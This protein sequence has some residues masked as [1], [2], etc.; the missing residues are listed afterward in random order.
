[1]RIISRTIGAKI[2]TANSDEVLCALPIPK[3]GKVLSVQGELHVIGQESLDIDNFMGYGFMGELVPIVDPTTAITAQALWDNVVVKAGDPTVSAGTN[4][5]DFDWDTLDTGPAIEPGELDIDKLLNLVQ[6]QKEI[7]A[8]RMEWLSWAKNKQGGWI[9]G[10]PDVF[11]PTD[12]KTFRSRKT[13]LADVPSM[14]MLAFSNPL[15][16]DVLLEAAMVTPSTE[17]EW[18]MMANMD[19]TLRD[20]G[21]INAGLIE[22]GAESP[23]AEASSLI[24]DLVAPDMLD[25]TTTKYASQ[26]YDVLCVATWVLEF[27]GESL[28]RTLDG[29]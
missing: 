5:L 22:V 7:I 28:P 8:P 18:Y 27:P 10:S 11:N 21:K 19:E 4:T 17:G 26:S 3:G 20:F 12:F 9:A 23:Y 6:G 1:M 25:E 14:A 13:V 16:S 24:R 29:R 15:L 2:S